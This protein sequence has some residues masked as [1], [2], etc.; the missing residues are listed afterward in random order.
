[1]GYSNFKKIRT[2]VKQFNLDMELVELFG[3]VAPVLPSPWLLEA[4][5]KANNT[6]LIN[7]KSKAERV[8]TP[9]LLEASDPYSDRISFFSGE[10]I[11]INPEQDLAGECDFFFALHPP[12][13]YMDAPIISLAESKDEDME[14]GIAQCAAQMYGAKLFNQQEGK[15]LPVLYGCA[16]DGLKWQFMRLENNIFHVDKRPLTDLTQVLGA[17][18]WIFQYY[19][20][21]APTA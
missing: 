10:A 19:L 14:W 5:R 9:V 3:P 13:L 8:V 20:K 18:H 15:D 12:K 21:V 7:E 2:V 4:I 17:W 11:N 16:T 6:P 1:M